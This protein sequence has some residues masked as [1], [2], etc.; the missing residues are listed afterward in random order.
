M[1]TSSGAGDLANELLPELIAGKDFSFPDIDLS[2]PKYDYNPDPDDP[3]YQNISKITIDDLTTKV[4]GGNGT[5][6]VIMTSVRAHLKD[7]YEKNRITGNDYVNAYIQLTQAALSGSLQFLLQKDQAFWQGALAKAQAKT[8]EIGVVTALVGVQTA[9]AQMAIARA[10]ALTAEVE[11]ALTKLKLATEDATYAQ[12]VAQTNQVLYQTSDL[13]PV[14]KLATQ[15]Q[16]EAARAQTLDTRTDG[17]TVVGSVGKQKDLYTQQITSYQ[18]D[19]EVKAAKLYTDAWTVMKT[20]DEG[21]DPPTSFANT[22]LQT[23][24]A[25]IQ[26][27]NNLS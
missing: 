12:L 19:S 2:D 27:N 3:I 21:L 10:Q 9:K 15:E 11:Y 4:V 23:V 16:A 8:A 18:R 13:L 22:N 17:Q 20:I 7:E 5:F 6:D 26:T 25:H 14:Q 24:L 1:A